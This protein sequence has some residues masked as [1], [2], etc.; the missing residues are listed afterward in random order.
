V[1]KLKPGREL[2][3]S[4]WSRGQ[5]FATGET[6]RSGDT[7][8]LGSRISATPGMADHE[9]QQV[10]GPNRISGTHRFGRSRRTLMSTKSWKVS[11][12]VRTS[13][14]LRA[15]P[16]RARRTG[17]TRNQVPPDNE[18]RLADNCK[19]DR[20]FCAVLSTSR[21]FARCPSRQADRVGE[22]EVC[23]SLVAEQFGDESG[24]GPGAAA[25]PG[26]HVD[27]L[28]GDGCAAL[29]A[30]HL[31]SE[32]RTAVSVS[33]AYGRTPSGRDPAVAP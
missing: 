4:C 1:C 23:S 13:D 31:G 28:G 8:R 25:G 10:R 18:P 22:C 16:L 12:P 30:V 21:G 29:R 2:K 15:R 20:A 11:N 33:E 3:R 26:Q 27:A 6:V 17:I 19:R 9:D 5:C 32:V 14:G 7:G 24:P